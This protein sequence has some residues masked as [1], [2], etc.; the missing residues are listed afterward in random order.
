M[1]ETARWQWKPTNV[2][3]RYFSTTAR[4]VT[5][6]RYICFA[7]LCNRLLH[8]FSW[9]V[10]VSPFYQS[11]QAFVMTI[12]ARL[13]PRVST[14]TSAHTINTSC[15]LGGSLDLIRVTSPGHLT[16]PVLRAETPL[17]GSWLGK[18]NLQTGSEESLDGFSVSLNA[19]HPQWMSVNQV[20]DQ[21]SAFFSNRESTRWLPQRFDQ[22]RCFYNRTR[23][24]RGQYWL[25]YRREYIFLGCW[26]PLGKTGKKK[27]ADCFYIRSLRWLSWYIFSAY[28]IKSA[29]LKTSQ[30]G[31]GLLYMYM[32]FFSEM[33]KGLEMECDWWND[34]NGIVTR[35]SFYF[36]CVVGCD[37][38]D[39]GFDI[40]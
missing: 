10:F 30:G 7:L 36:F 34:M 22:G 35:S 24:S 25:P 26:R 15:T 14:S 38:V 16:L 27:L 18:A 29:R 5:L 1:T 8:W 9:A 13:I 32:G 20:S 39:D 31:Y 4:R 3:T 21:R 37:W 6:P 12:P 28:V 11:L 2:T 40:V 23:D 17:L 33:G 19:L